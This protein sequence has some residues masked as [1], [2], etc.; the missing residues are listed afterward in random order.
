MR[1]K[2]LTGI[3]CTICFCAALSGCAAG[4]RMTVTQKGQ[5][6]P[7]DELHLRGKWAFFETSSQDERIL[8]AFA[9]PGAVDGKRQYFLYL[10]PPPQKGT[11]LFGTGGNVAPAD[12]GGTKPTSV[13]RARG[14]FLQRCGPMAGLA[15]I[16][17]GTLVVGGAPFDGGRLRV[18]RFD[19]TC[20]DGTRLTGDFT[21]KRDLLEMRSFEEDLYPA[22]VQALSE[23]DPPGSRR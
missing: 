14:F 20:T 4:A 8:L 23:S 12:A 5:P 17:T 2:T 11:H 16:A 19:L 21:A 13:G 15:E 1:E 3:T 7:F 18:G 9:H 22:D 10:R 6:P